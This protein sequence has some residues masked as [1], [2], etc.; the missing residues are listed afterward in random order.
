MQAVAGTVKLLV[1]LVLGSIGLYTYGHNS[2]NKA[3]PYIP[4]DG[5]AI[6]IQA[7]TAK[8]ASCDV[9]IHQECT[10][11]SWHPT[12][13][14]ACMWSWTC[15]WGYYE[16]EERTVHCTYTC[17]NGYMYSVDRVENQWHQKGCCWLGNPNSATRTRVP[18]GSKELP[19]RK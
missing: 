4:Q 5:G 3:N 11:A 7:S 16:E 14:S 17:K 19:C 6:R 12:G 8:D 18:P 15:I 2:P 13:L 1:L 10:T 9:I